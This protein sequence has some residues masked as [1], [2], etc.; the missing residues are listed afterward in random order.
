MIGTSRSP[1][2]FEDLMLSLLA[3]VWFSDDL[4]TLIPELLLW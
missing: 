4:V 3:T 1:K 2:L